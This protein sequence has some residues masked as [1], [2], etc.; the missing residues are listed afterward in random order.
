MLKIDS[1]SESANPS[2]CE[3]RQ[4]FDQENA[5]KTYLTSASPEPDDFPVFW[6]GQVPAMLQEQETLLWGGW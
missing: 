3:G 5:P 4:I 2:Y 6:A 1:K